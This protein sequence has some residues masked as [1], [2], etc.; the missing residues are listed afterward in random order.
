MKGKFMKSVVCVICGLLVAISL[1]AADIKYDSPQ[2]FYANREI[3]L[4][5][6]TDGLAGR[7]FSWNVRYSGLTIAAAELAVPETGAVEIKFTFPEIKEG[8]SATAE[9]VCVSGDKKLQKNLFF[10]APNP[11]A[12]RK[13]VLEKNKIGLWSPSGDDTAKKLFESLGVATVDV[14]NFADFKERLLVVVGIDFSNF[15]GLEKDIGGICSSGSNILIINPAG[16]ALP[17]KTETFKNMLFSRNEK[18]LEF[19]KKFDPEKWG[20]SLPN[21]KS[22]GLAPSDSAAALNVADNRN[23]F[24]FMSAKIGKGELVVCSWDIFGKA[25]KSPTPLYLLEKLIAGIKQE[26]AGNRQQAIENKE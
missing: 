8:V 13:K 22:L 12:F 9:L 21:E 20:D 15:S 10:F 2:S 16:G 17:L 25:E 1:S 19:D 14:A 11:F 7:N 24:T 23:G 6:R 26:A 5:I 3:V 4:N 18:I